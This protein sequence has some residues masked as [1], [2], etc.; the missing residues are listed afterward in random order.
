LHGNL[1]LGQVQR[2]PT[3]TWSTVVSYGSAPPPRQRPHNARSSE[4]RPDQ[5]L[6]IASGSAAAIECDDGAAAITC[7][8]VHRRSTN[9]TVASRCDTVLDGDTVATMNQQVVS[10]SRIIKATPEA[11][12]AVIADPARHADFDGSGMVQQLRGNDQRL[13]LGSKFGMD[14]K[15]GP[16]PYRIS[17]TVVEFEENRLIA[18]AHAGKHRWRYE[19]E[20]VDG[21]TRV[22]ESFDWS[23][24]RFPKAIELMGYPKKHP[25]NL[26]ATLERLATLVEGAYVD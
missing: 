1:R 11:I 8:I 6:S 9:V 25:A 14:M 24:S 23:T 2:H 13:K 16:L 3:S 21:A 5:R 4:P 7:S 20:P 18:W 15:I 10:E 17:S 26:R 22:T 19:L 12:F